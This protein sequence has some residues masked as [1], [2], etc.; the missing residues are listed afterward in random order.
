MAHIIADR[1]KETS[2]TEGTG[3]FTLGGATTGSVTFNAAMANNDTCDYCIEGLNPDGTLSGQWE[4][5]TGTYIDTDTLVRTSVAAS[6]N[7]N[8]HVNF[9]AGT[10][11][12]FLTLP[13]SKVSAIDSLSTIVPVTGVWTPVIEGTTTTGSGTYSSQ[14]GT[15][16]KIGKLVFISGSLQWTA[17]TGTGNIRIAGLPYTANASAPLSMRYEGLTFTG[18]PTSYATI[19]TKIVNIMTQATGAAFAGIP[20]DTAANIG[21][22]GCYLTDE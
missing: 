3:N 7:S 10:K 6:S 1:V 14:T 22:A 2:T 19:G 13:A 11:N 18:I 4:V 5:G 17:H 9:S 8:S 20:M 16:Y 15:F 12:V 21:V